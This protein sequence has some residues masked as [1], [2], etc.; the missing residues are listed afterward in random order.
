M[1][2]RM[3]GVVRSTDVA[4]CARVNVGAAC[5]AFGAPGCGQS[6]AD[7]VFV[8]GAQPMGGV[9]RP[10][11][12]CASVARMM[13]RVAVALAALA[14][15]VAVVGVL[16]ES[17][18]GGGSLPVVPAAMADDA[19]P[20]QD[21]SSQ[22]DETQ[23]TIT[24]SIT[25]TENLLGGDAA[26]VN[27]AINKTKA[28]T[29]VSV[30]LLYL[31]N[32]R[33]GV[34]PEQ[35]A[36]QTLESTSP[37]PNT[38]MLAVATQDGNLVVAV[39][40]NS[41]EWLKKTATV[42][43]LSEAA[44]GPIL[45]NQSDPDWPGSAKAMMEAIKK[46]KTTSTSSAATAIGIWVFVAVLALLVMA[47]VVFF[48]L[49]RRRGSRHGSKHAGKRARG[50]TRKRTGKRAHSHVRKRSGKRSAGRADTGESQTDGL[51]G[52][53]ASPIGSIE[54]SGDIQKTSSEGVQSGNHEQAN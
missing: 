53:T 16:P 49:H 26:S 36:S 43:Q 24:D 42:D 41:D 9:S 1:T 34:D 25:D 45:A 27:D 19:T 39:S 54:V 20:S 14:L 40:S 21:A 30:R 6:A 29:G 28:E 2:I 4:E 50:S 11:S 44:V 13:R 23:M 3:N 35:W 37:E 46:A 51:S 10:R 33:Q 52:E 31:P 5:R 47:G 15:A 17:G 22:D 7:A 18:S 38:V 48:I 12:R 8:D 32:F